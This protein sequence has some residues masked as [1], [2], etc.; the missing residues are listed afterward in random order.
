MT[1]S[2]TSLPSQPHPPPGGRASGR[3][4]DI[5]VVGALLLLWGYVVYR[6][7]TLWHSNSDYAFGWFVPLLCLCLF[8][9][10]W[11]RRPARS[12][13]RPAGGTFFLFA[14]FGC[15]LLPAALFLEIIPNW[16]FAGWLFAG[17]VIG[18]TLILL[19][20]LGGRNW[21]RFF[22]F[23]VIFFLIAV[24]WPTR[25][26]APLIEKMSKL[27]AAVSAVSA[28]VLGSPA[29]RHGVL[30]E[31]GTGFVGV[32]EAC[33]G[34]RSFQA[35][36]MVALF[37][38]ELFG[39]SI[40]RRG[41]LLSGS[42]A[43]A[44][45][46]NVI[47]TTYLVRE[48]DL[49]GLAAVNLHHDQAGLTILGVT[50]L[51]LL[52]LVWLLRH[53]RRGGA[54]NFPPSDSRLDYLDELHN[55]APGS[56]AE[57]Q[58]PAAPANTLAGRT[59]D[60]PT[61]GQTSAAGS[62]H[63]WLINAA[64]GVLVIWVALIETGVHFWF[65]PAEKEA[66][67][68]A[69][70]S[71]KLPM[72]AAEFRELPISENVRAM[73]NY[74]E[75]RQAEWRDGG[76]CAWQLFYFRWLPAEDRYRAAVTCGQARGHSPDVCLRNAGMILETNLG[77]Q[78]MTVDGV[79]LQVG[80]ERFRDQGRELD[81]FS[82]YWEPKAWVSQAVPGTL[83]AI[84]TVLHALATHDRGRNEKRVIKMGV[85]GKESDAAAQ[86]AFQEYLPLMISR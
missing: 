64:L 56:G 79:R 66:A 47:R 73:L 70:W 5:A 48:A 12:S 25:L 67:T 50:L 55:L 44:F 27:N 6:L 46:G 37:L 40:L 62:G 86:A 43:L 54:E 26:E 82:C 16:R 24:P 59:E 21:S 28:N 78:T 51:G 85:W 39:Y 7:G 75:G 53:R 34:I 69:N 63:I 80:R 52:A 19:Y 32:D 23:P 17:T 29:V 71:F 20:F 31:T 14:M 49:H 68:F 13:V 45:G 3:N 60:Q 8:W 42:V 15:L 4:L 65:T 74:N 22:A 38:G 57:K 58:N 10:R 35:S 2:A 61:A 76:G 81:V 84:H 83:M 72:Q 9:E 1:S 30:I 41:I 77:T 18:L 11:K 33:S 36:I